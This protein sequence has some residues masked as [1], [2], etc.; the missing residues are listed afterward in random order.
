MIPDNFKYAD[1]KP[2]IGQS[3]SL[4]KVLRKA[5]QVADSSISVMIE[6]ETGTGKELIARAIHYQSPREN[7]RFEAI[8]CAAITETLAESELFG[9]E[10]GAFTGADKPKT[11]KFELAHD[12]TLFLDEIGDLPLLQQAKVLRAIQEGEFYRVGGTKLIRVNVRI[13]C[14][15]NI[16]LFQAVQEKR[17][18]RDL[19]YRLRVAQIP[20]PSLRERK[21]DIPLLAEHF[22]KK[23]NKK[24]RANITGISAKTLE[25]L[26]AHS[27]PGNIRE[28][29]NAIWK[30]VVIRKQGIIQPDDID[31]AGEQWVDNKLEIDIPTGKLEF[32]DVMETVTKTAAQKIVGVAMAKSNGNTVLAKEYLGLKR[33]DNVVKRYGVDLEKIEKSLPQGG[34]SEEE[35]KKQN[36]KTDCPMIAPSCLNAR[37]K[38]AVQY[39]KTNHSLTAEQYGHLTNTSRR[40]A[41]R[42]IKELV[43]SGI[44]SMIGS[45]R[46]ISYQLITK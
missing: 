8:N 36:G 21:E 40:T 41:L 24:D 25:L 34:L 18:R 19:F 14:A 39:L 20:V 27:W 6:G 15:T 26:T 1:D 28:L 11:G 9:H 10:K 43:D 5:L 32:Y 35:D 44:V 29:E 7:M 31:I 12:G 4:L 13:I 38:E 22:W 37:Q 42:E 17:F 23:Y 30:A 46:N 16:D 3:S 2:I 33:W 45:S